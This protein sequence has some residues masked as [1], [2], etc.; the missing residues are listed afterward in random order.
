MFNNDRNSSELF[1]ARELLH[2]SNVAIYCK[3][4]LATILGGKLSEEVFCRPSTAPVADAARCFLSRVCC[5]L[6][7]LLVGAGGR[8]DLG[9]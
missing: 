5:V 4:S 6:K 2:D 7:W 9:L 1:L 3:K 8:G